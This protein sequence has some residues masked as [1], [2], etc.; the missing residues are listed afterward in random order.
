MRCCPKRVRYNC[1][2]NWLAIQEPRLFRGAKL[3]RPQRA[4]GAGGARP[5]CK[6]PQHTASSCNTVGISPDSYLPVQSSPWLRVRQHFNEA[7]FARQGKC[8]VQNWSA[9]E[10]DRRWCGSVWKR[11]VVGGAK[12]RKRSILHECCT[13]SPGRK[14]WVFYVD[15][16]KMGDSTARH[17]IDASVHVVCSL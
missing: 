16:V 3:Q 7:R 5:Q 11:A 12:T 17:A 6:S 9:G 4:S 10:L 13:D 2:I 15:A 14:G 8:K 1:N